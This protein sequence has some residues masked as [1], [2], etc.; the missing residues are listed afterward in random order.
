MW[1]HASLAHQGMGAEVGTRPA[2]APHADR[3]SAQGEGGV[4]GEVPPPP[5][6]LQV[7]G[8]HRATMF[9]TPGG[10]ALSDE[11]ARRPVWVVVGPA[12]GAPDEGSAGLLSTRLLSSGRPTSAYKEGGGKRPP[13]RGSAAF[14]EGGCGTATGTA[15]CPAPSTVVLGLR[16]AGCGR[17]PLAGP[18]RAPHEC[19]I[20]VGIGAHLTG[21]AA[22]GRV[23]GGSPAA[24]CA[25]RSSTSPRGGRTTDLGAAAATATAATSAHPSTSKNGS[26]TADEPPRPWR[27][28]R[29]PELL[30]KQV[31]ERSPAPERT[32][33]KARVERKCA[34]SPCAPRA[35]PPPS[36]APHGSSEKTHSLSGFGLLGGWAIVRR[37]S[38]PPLPQR[39]G[40]GGGQVGGLNSR[41]K[42]MEAESHMEEGD[43][44]QPPPPPSTLVA[45]FSCISAGLAAARQAP[46][47]SPSRPPPTTLPYPHRR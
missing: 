22:A 36:P 11:E 12:S 23:K 10:N 42:S 44:P 34:H 38:P 33:R 7:R 8:A 46:G 43:P 15:L 26:D 31:R 30:G 27:C 47:G 16:T 1:G 18:R 19:G 24:R 13:R 45:V 35:A 37:P 2:T 9:C 28:Y 39:G 21:V 14:R 20:S 29:R 6:G 25:S 40:E 41:G 17:V 4:D 5:G 3:L 32:V